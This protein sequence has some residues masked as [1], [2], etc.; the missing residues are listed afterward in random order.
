MITIG[1]GELIRIC[2]SDPKRIEYS[3]DNGSCWYSRGSNSY[4]FVDLINFENEILGVSYHKSVYYSRDNGSCWYTRSNPQV[5]FSSL[6]NNGN[7]LLGMGVDGHTYYSTDK[8]SCWYYR[9]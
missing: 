1:N 6:V 7:E 2:P 9:N 3:H 5:Q 8:G 4:P